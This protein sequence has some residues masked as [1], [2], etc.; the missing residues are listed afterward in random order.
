MMKMPDVGVIDEIVMDFSIFDDQRPIEPSAREVEQ[1]QEKV[2]N[3]VNLGLG[4]TNKHE[5]LVDIG[6]SPLGLNNDKQTSI[7]IGKFTDSGTVDDMDA[8]WEIQDLLGIATTKNKDRSRLNEID[9]E[10]EEEM[11]EIREEEKRL[12]TQVKEIGLEETQRQIN[13]EVEKENKGEKE[14]G[15]NNN[16]RETG[17][18]TNGSN[19]PKKQ[20]LGSIGEI[21]RKR[22]LQEVEDEIMRELREEDKK[23]QKQIKEIGFEET[24]KRI[25][26]EIL[27]ENETQKEQHQEKKRKIEEKEKEMTK[28]ERVVV[29]GD[30]LMANFSSFIRNNKDKFDIE[31]TVEINY[32]RGANLDEILM[33]V[34]EVVFEEM[35]GVLIIQGGG[36]NLLQEG[37]VLQWMKIVNTIQ[38]VWRKN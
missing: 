12:Q 35:G 15:K 18:E 24:I 33:K 5:I 4:E 23:L 6:S 28:K 20:E 19:F 16:E 36:N 31:D 21:K 10:W 8:E 9:E 38:E 30:S 7:E 1:N 22:T 25:N 14:I 26:E 37:A 32:K 17:K 34:R 13:K 3:G 11:K 29:V 2:R 27:I